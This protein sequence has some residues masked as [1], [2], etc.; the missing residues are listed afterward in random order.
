MRNK[1]AVLKEY[2]SGLKEKGQ[3]GGTSTQKA[4]LVSSC[5]CQSKQESDSMPGVLEDSG[6][7]SCTN[8]WLE[9]ESRGSKTAVVNRTA[10]F[11]DGSHMV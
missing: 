7:H 3:L 11:G 8:R 2:I 5:E 6:C 1:R 10:L 9:A 4:S